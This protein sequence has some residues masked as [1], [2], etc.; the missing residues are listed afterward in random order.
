[1]P[2]EIVVASWNVHAGVDGWGRRFDVAAICR[3]ID[4]DVMVLQE[5]WSS[6]RGHGL[7][8][9]VGEILGYQVEEATM[10]RALMLPPPPDPGRGWGP[11]PLGRARYGPRIERMSRG[12]E[13]DEK[14][15][16]RSTGA[17]S[18]VERGT[19][20]LA[21]LSRLKVEGVETW[22]LGRRN[23]GRSTR[24]CAIAVQVAK[25]EPGSAELRRML[26]VGMHLSHLRQGSLVQLS[27]LRGVLGSRHH[28]GVPTVLAGDMNMPGLPLSVLLPGWKPAVRGRTWPAW[29]PLAQSDHVLLG[30]VS[31]G[32]GSGRGAVVQVQGSDHLPVRARLSL[33]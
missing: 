23:G 17:S 16:A 30:G 2:V 7:A 22:D 15:S 31:E 25:C 18:G 32:N 12:S 28:L 11:L 8:P 14:G 10:A 19:V 9:Q 5:T 24:R 1:M 6:D 3:S 21:V 26:V 20:G 29:C 33:P 13:P 4:A 27:R